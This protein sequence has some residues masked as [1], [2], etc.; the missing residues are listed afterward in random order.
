MSIR[1][2]END[3]ELSSLLVASIQIEQ[4][5]RD[6]SEQGVKFYKELAEFLDVR[7]SSCNLKR[8]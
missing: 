1:G 7:N 4:D 6:E 5:N 8:L 3:S 2:E